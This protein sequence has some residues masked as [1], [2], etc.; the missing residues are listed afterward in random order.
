MCHIHESNR[1]VKEKRLIVHRTRV[2][3]FCWEFLRELW[4]SLWLL[5]NVW[6]QWYGRH[7]LQDWTVK[8]SEKLK[9]WHCSTLHCQ[10]PV[11]SSVALLVRRRHILKMHSSDASRLRFDQ[12]ATVVKIMSV[13]RISRMPLMVAVAAEADHIAAVEPPGSCSIICTLVMF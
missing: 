3:C 9:H 12:H 5:H 7:K 10:R 4:V 13:S 6:I 11:M 8:V 2:I 1:V